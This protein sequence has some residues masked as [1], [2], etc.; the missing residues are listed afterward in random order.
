MCWV[1]ESSSGSYQL[2]GGDNSCI[3]E[4]GGLHSTNPGLPVVSGQGAHSALLTPLTGSPSL[5]PG[6]ERQL[7]DTLALHWAQ[8]GSA[9][10]TP[11]MS[12]ASSPSSPGDK[13]KDNDAWL[14]GAFLPI[15][16]PRSLSTNS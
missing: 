13:R 12:W 1:W 3:P 14:H 11:A 15:A 4:T 10:L 9:S 16:N 7:R 6:T 8:L 5:C 2:L